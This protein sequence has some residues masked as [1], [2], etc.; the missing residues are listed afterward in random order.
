M[1]ITACAIMHDKDEICLEKERLESKIQPGLQTEL[2]GVIERFERRERRV[3]DFR[4]LLRKTNEHK[5]SFRWV[6]R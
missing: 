4:Y 2:V 3:G 6:E 1:N 5:F